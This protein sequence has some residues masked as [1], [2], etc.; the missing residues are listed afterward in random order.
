MAQY[1]F[2]AEFSNNRPI[3]KGFTGFA[4]KDDAPIKNTAVYLRPNHAFHNGKINVVLWFHGFYV[5]DVRDLVQPV[6]AGMEMN[7][8]DSVRNS[9]KDAVLIAPWLGL[10]TS[11]ATGS[12]A[13]GS[14]GEGT[15]CQA[16]LDQVIDGLLRFRQSMS[17][18]AS[19]VLEI[20]NLIIA[21]HSAGGA[22]MKDASKHLGTYK[23]KVK[24]YW[25]FDCFYDDGYSAWLRDNP[26]P[27]K[28][29]Y[30]GNGSGAHGY[31]A[32]KLMKEVYGTLKQPV[33]PSRQIPNMYL[34][35]AVDKVFTADDNYAFEPIEDPNDWGTRR[36][37]YTDVRRATDPSLKNQDQGEYW[38]K[39]LPKLTEHFQVV[40]DLLGPRIQQSK[41]L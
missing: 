39:I 2:K 11:S 13:L 30:F 34:A 28:V 36:N 8:R 4:E 19:S 22:L 6:N 25:G 35:P 27:D 29:F 3:V 1:E 26:K 31:Y 38:S 10:K 32:F 5:E 18:E 12:L 14:L 41:W 16:Y 7:L 24:E 20:G 21:G 40:R 15:G 37:P 33:P 17:K 23:D 9:N